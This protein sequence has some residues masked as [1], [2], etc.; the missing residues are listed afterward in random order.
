VG[1][2]DATKIAAMLGVPDGWTIF[3]VLPFGYPDPSNPPQPRPLKA[4]AAMVH[5][6]R[7]GNPPEMKRLS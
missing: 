7:Y 1:N 2:F 5:F 3:T 6:E 4:R